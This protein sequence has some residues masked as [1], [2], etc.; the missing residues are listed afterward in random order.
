MDLLLSIV[1]STFQLL[2]KQ[3]I[4]KLGKV[5]NIWLQARFL[6]IDNNFFL[7]VI[8]IRPILFPFFQFILDLA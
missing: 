8:L 2:F 3:I 7:A 6:V 4:H 1:F 5:I